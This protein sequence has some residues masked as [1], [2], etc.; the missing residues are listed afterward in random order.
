LLL[1]ELRESS[2]PC[3]VDVW[4]MRWLP[5]CVLHLRSLCGLWGCLKSPFEGI[6]HCGL[7]PQSPD[8][9]ALKF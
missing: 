7:D 8:K 3:K 9:T 1:S 2:T 4:G 6:C 5:S